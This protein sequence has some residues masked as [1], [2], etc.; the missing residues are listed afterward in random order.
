MVVVVKSFYLN[1]SFFFNM[2][3]TITKS[4]HKTT[5]PGVINNLNGVIIEIIIPY[6]FYCIL[7]FST[8]YKVNDT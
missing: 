3:L 7:D 2:H 8:S 4:N 5:G 1:I 6:T